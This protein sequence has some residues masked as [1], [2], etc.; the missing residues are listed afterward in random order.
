MLAFINLS[1][2]RGKDALVM[3]ELVNKFAPNNVEMLR[4]LTYALVLENRG[5]DALL[6]AE[7]LLKLDKSPDSEA[8]ILLL[9]SRAL[10]AQKR[11]PEARAMFRAFVRARAEQR[12]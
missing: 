5:E 6:S 3:L 4:A 10:L 1:Q 11:L 8:S 7:R 2:G 12:Q 9:R